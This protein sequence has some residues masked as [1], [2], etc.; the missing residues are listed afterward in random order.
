MVKKPPFTVEVPGCEPVPG[1]TIPR[2]LPKAKDGLILKPSEDV[3]TTYEN[4]RRSARVFGNAKA[5]GSRRLIKTHVEK[6]KVKK[7][8]DGQEQEVEKQWTYYE[9][10]A[11]EYKSFVEYEQ[12]ALQL[13]AGLRKLGLEKDQR[14]HVYGA[15]SANWLAMSHGAAS[16]SMP[17]VTAYDTLGEA[18]LKHSIVQTLSIAMF[19]DPN[20]IS[21]VKNV[22]GDAKSIQYVIYNSDMDVKQE[23]LDALK[24]DFD[25]LTILS[26]EELRKLGEDNPVDPVPPSPE[27]LCCI[28][29]TSGSTGPPKGVPLTHANVIA[30]SKLSCAFG[31]D[32]S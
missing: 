2:R 5:V 3:S 14:I 20:L 18:G 15:T 1:E 16:Q 31:R 10:S 22:L 23:D 25:Y 24:K 26:F 9:M 19:C 28:M 29:Y 27:D 13:G 30:A 7:I 4:F 21:S 32:S 11:Y 8:V 6:K 17:I 12:L